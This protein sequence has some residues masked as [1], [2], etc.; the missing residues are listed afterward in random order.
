MHLIDVQEWQ[1]L[2][3]CP[4]AGTTPAPVIKDGGGI[5][6]WEEAAARPAFPGRGVTGRGALGGVERLLHPLRGEFV[7]V[8]A[9]ALDGGGVQQRIELGE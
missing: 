9:R 3:A 7:A 6:L 1:V 8:H 5:F 4:A 2:A